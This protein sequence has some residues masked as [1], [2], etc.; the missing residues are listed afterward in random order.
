MLS[1]HEVIDA[2]CVFSILGCVLALYQV[3]PELG[4]PVQL[5]SKH[6]KQ[7]CQQTASIGRDLYSVTQH[8]V[9]VDTMSPSKLHRASIPGEEIV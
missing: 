3:M 9:T 7:E 8:T 2:A 1:S 5:H 6:I 4:I